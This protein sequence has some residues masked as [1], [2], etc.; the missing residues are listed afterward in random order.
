MKSKTNNV[1]QPVAQSSVQPSDA[2]PIAD[3]PAVSDTQPPAVSDT[4]LALSPELLPVEQA[5]QWVGQPHC[6]AVVVFCGN[7][8]DHSTGREGV[9]LL[10]Y[11]AYEEHAVTRMGEVADA[12][13]KRW[14]AVA[15]IAMLHRTGKVEIGDAAVVVAVS[16][17]HRQEAFQAA[18][19][20][21]DT[22][23][24]TVPIWKR[25]R[26]SEGESWGLEAQH[27]QEISPN[28]RLPLPEG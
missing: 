12:T 7:A 13:R 20:C 24:T 16:S 1:T 2:R 6:G 27:I 23:K 3:L 28:P 18:S 19:F 14:P 8:R 5:R 25:E 21:I 11:E 26:W 17:P 15:R 9:E 22:L 10:E 4:W